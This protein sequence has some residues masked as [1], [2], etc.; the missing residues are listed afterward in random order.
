MTAATERQRGPQLMNERRDN[1]PQLQYGE[2]KIRRALYKT[3]YNDEEEAQWR[4][5]RQEDHGRNRDKGL[6]FCN[7]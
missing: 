7:M 3:V 2:R 4:Y 6:K 1:V 5:K